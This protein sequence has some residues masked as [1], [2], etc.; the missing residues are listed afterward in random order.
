M[1]RLRRAS[2]IATL[3]LVASVTTAYAECAWVLWQREVIAKRDIG[4]APR[5]SFKDISECKK[6]ESKA[7]MRYNADTQKLG[8]I[9]GGHTVCL[10]DTVDLR[11]PK[12][13]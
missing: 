6:K 5:E 1:M 12:G 3:S 10:P 4:W 8:P 11:G 13:K 9:P 7:D 2:A